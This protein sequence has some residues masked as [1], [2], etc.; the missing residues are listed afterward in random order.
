ML[1]EAYIKQDGCN[2]EPERPT[3]HGPLDAYTCERCTFVA[4]MDAYLAVR[5]PKEGR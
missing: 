2:C 4:A 1:A 5:H 3:P